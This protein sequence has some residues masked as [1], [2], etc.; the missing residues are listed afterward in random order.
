MKIAVDLDDTILGFMPSFLDFTGKYCNRHYKAD[1]IE[2]YLFCKTLKCTPEEAKV[3]VEVFL[4]LSPLEDIP[5]VKDAKRGVEHLKNIGCE[6]III[7][8]RNQVFEDR[9]RKWLEQVNLLQYFDKIIFTNKFYTGAMSKAE[10]CVA[11]NVDWIIDDCAE[12][13]IDCLLN[14]K[15][16]VMLF[17]SPWNRGEIYKEFIKIRNKVDAHKIN[18]W[19][20]LS[21]LKVYS[22]QHIIDEMRWA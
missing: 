5:M 12:N 1:D 19:D 6:L 13:C 14:S 16:S 8:A 20:V 17:D 3:L 15:T 9:T 22:W 2:E 7:T 18:T 21:G 11:E 10:V 4:K